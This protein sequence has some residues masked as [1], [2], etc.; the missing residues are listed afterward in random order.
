MKIIFL[1]LYLIVNFLILK[2][3]LHIFQLNYYMP[4]TQ[5]KWI[6]KNWQ[7]FSLVFIL[8]IVGAFSILFYGK[9][10]IAIITLGLNIPSII[11]KN[12]KKKIVYT[13]RIKRMFLSNY[14]ILAILGIILH[15]KFNIFASIVLLF[16]SLT[17]TLSPTLAF[18]ASSVFVIV[19]I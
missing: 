11:E 13:N 9:Y 8:N 16:E 3:N 15:N 12:V 10:I 7:K 2:Y 6:K 1:I 17:F 5:L 4:D 19:A 14:L 18:L